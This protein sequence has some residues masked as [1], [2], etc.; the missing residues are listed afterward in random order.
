MRGLSDPAATARELTG[1]ERAVA[2]LF[3]SGETLLSAIRGHN[4]GVHPLAK[5]A[6]QFGLLYQRRLAGLTNESNCSRDE[7]ILAVDMWVADHLPVPHPSSTLHTETLGAVIN[8]LA[9]A[10]VRAYH[11]LMTVDPA[12]PS[13]HAA[14]YRL[15]ELVDGYTDLTKE[16]TRRAR[17]LPAPARRR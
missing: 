11:L 7:F 3:P 10:Q 13:V 6:H 4:V 9:E 12:D 17:R 1:T 16:V 8:R 5:S 2:V 14:W 15:A